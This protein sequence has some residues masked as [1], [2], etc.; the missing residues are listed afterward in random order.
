V[1]VK[2]A[3]A[4]FVVL[5]TLLASC[6]SEAEDT[7]I[8][9]SAAASLSTA[10]TEI[11][12]AYEAD[13]DGV[14]VQLNFAGSTTLQQQ[15]IG[16]APVDVFASADVRALQGV[17]EV[18]VADAVQRIFATNSLTI[19]VPGGNPGGISDLEDFENPDL[20]LGL[21]AIP[22]PCGVYAHE[23]FGNAGVVPSI[24]TEESDVTSLVL[25]IELGELDGGIVYLTDVDSRGN[26]ID[27]VPIP[28][29]Y[30]VTA[31]YPIVLLNPDSDAAAAFVS[32]VLSDQGRSI[33]AA[34]GFGLP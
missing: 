14:T 18:S 34:H 28:D 15:I 22:V 33:L 4:G 6:S 2:Q 13:N 24:D 8:L 12:A 25:K 32:F 21:C 26:S 1:A 3:L 9:V 29:E 10:F 23:M 16:G 5:V 20:F 19:A 27:R 7:T 11:A 17:V 30:N 31:T